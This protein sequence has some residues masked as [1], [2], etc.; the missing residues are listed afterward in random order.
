MASSTWCLARA[1]VSPGCA[2]R[3][4]AAAAVA[5]L[6][7]CCGA[8]SETICWQTQC[9]EVSDCT[10]LVLVDAVERASQRHLGS[11]SLLWR[12]EW[13]CGRRRWWRQLV[14]L[15]GGGRTDHTKRFH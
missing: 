2:H 7:P 10:C 1:S 11:N 9:A 6:D 12:G 3:L 15:I 4:S 14:R 13:R 5:P 8:A